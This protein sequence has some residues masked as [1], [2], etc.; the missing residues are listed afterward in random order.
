MHGLGKEPYKDRYNEEG[1]G[2]TRLGIP[3]SENREY[4]QRKDNKGG[5]KLGSTSTA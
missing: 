5:D 2:N 1:E 4:A 3:F